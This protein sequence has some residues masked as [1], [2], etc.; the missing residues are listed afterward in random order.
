MH[1]IRTSSRDSDG[2][3]EVVGVPLSFVCGGPDTGFGC[4]CAGADLARLL[5]LPGE[6]KLKSRRNMASQTKK[7]DTS[8]AL[9]GVKVFGLY[10]GKGVNGIVGSVSG[11]E[12]PKRRKIML[13][14]IPRGAREGKRPSSSVG[15]VETTTGAREREHRLEGCS[16]IM[17]PTIVF[18][19]VNGVLR[20][21]RALA[22][23]T[24]WGF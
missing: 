8:E 11:N 2:S 6:K 13:K 10:S 21:T 18:Q 15:E 14:T 7:N 23:A 12:L 16:R 4:S 24:S 17:I 19:R 1:P 20:A 3:R 22:R 5:L 9:K